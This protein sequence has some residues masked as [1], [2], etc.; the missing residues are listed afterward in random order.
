MVA[1]GVCVDPFGSVYMAGFSSASD[2]G[3]SGTH[4]S[5]YSGDYDGFL[6]KFC[7]P[8]VI[9]S[10]L[11]D[12]PQYCDELGLATAQATGGTTGLQYTWLGDLSA[13]G[14]T[15]L[16]DPGTEGSVIVT[17]PTGVCASSDTAE[18]LIPAVPG[19]EYTTAVTDVLCAGDSS[20][21]IDLTITQG[22]PPYHF[23]WTGNVDSEDLSGVPAGDYD[24]YVTDDHNCVAELEFVISEP[25][26][27]S[28]SIVSTSG[29]FCLGLPTGSI[30]LDASGGVP[31]Y[32]YVWSDGSTVQDL[33]GIPAGTYVA[34]ITDANDCSTTAEVTLNE[35]DD[36]VITGVITDESAGNDG[37][38]DITVSGGTPEYL[39]LWSNDST[40]EDLIGL[41]GGVYTV[42][43]TDANG[44]M[45]S[46]QAEVGSSV[47]FDLMRSGE[48]DRVMFDA[49]ANQLILTSASNPSSVDLF[50]DTGRTVLSRR[51]SGS[52]VVIPV[53]DVRT[54]IYLVRWRT[55]VGFRSQRI[56]INNP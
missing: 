10:L 26:P 54:G 56:L 37:A 45:D 9:E 40:I 36:L 19:L 41:V 49:G 30:D 23:D 42:H 24:L 52:P 11:I 39:Y 15:A 53:P 27:L 28:A 16:Y 34:T 29:P 25:L 2:L 22:T 50:D 51:Y 5:T 38:I 21:G 46:L 20:G 6:V 7:S 3:T 55:A 44:C 12:D 43:V 8:V 32:A 13:S 31:G 48:Q 18:V 47:G 4:Q 17:S 1:A 33:S 14:N 35:P